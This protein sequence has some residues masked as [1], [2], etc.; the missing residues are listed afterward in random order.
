MSPTISSLFEEQVARTPGAPA[1]Q[2]PDAGRELSYRDLS[3]EANRL[4]QALVARGLP[5]AGTVAVCLPQGVDRI[6]AFLAAGKAGA[7]YVSMDPALPR[8]RHE[9][10]AGDS[11]ADIV[12]TVEE[13]AGHFPG[14]PALLVD[15]DR[16]EIAAMP[17]EAPPARPANEVAIIYYTSGTTGTPKG[18]LASHEGVAHFLRSLR[19]PAL[20]P[21]DRMAQINNPAFDA[22]TFEVYGALTSG[23]C[24]VIISRDLLTDPAEFGEAIKRHGITTA[25]VATSVFHEIAAGNPAAFAPMRVL[26][27]GGEALDPRR[28]RDVLAVGRPGHLLNAYGP[29]ETT[30]FVTWHEVTAVADD[31]RFIPIGLPLGE[32]RAYVLDK[33]LRP[34][35][36]GEAG[37]LCLA[38]P[39]LALGYLGRPELT[40]AAFVPDPAVPGELMYRTGDFARRGAGGVLEFTGRIDRQV[41]LRGY[42]IELGEIEAQVV[43]HPD[44]AGGAV[45]VEGE[46]DGRR[47]AAYVVPAQGGDGDI[48][49]RLRAY[50][51][52]RLP[53]W[54]VPGL[55]VLDR[56]PLTPTGKLDRAA[57][58]ATVE[59]RRAEAGRTHAGLTGAD[60]STAGRAHASLTSAGAG[61][62]ALGSAG[63]AGSDQVG[64]AGLDGVAPLESWLAGV[65][66]ELTGIAPKGPDD[67]F[68]VIG[69]HSV[70]VG[71]LRARVRAVLGTQPPLRDY[72]R[73]S[74]LSEQAAMLRRHDAGRNLDALVTALPDRQAQ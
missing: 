34:V 72:F 56:L 46:G 52:E 1:I 22:T 49:G 24:L 69:G 36:D 74:R 19:D 42:R 64:G 43:A 21:S 20:S 16:A 7:A 23:G 27:V 47:L 62:G 38:G 54:M 59:E 70:L 48:P 45:I 73:N 5:A 13:L 40:E 17:P 11:R 39:C 35:P 3:R 26:V 41:K 33:D 10:I 28:A 25:L 14:T 12:I 37:E 71:R 61:A 31:T 53:L 55:T 67:D 60:A 29:T 58:S 8:A 32:V 2:H 15:A 18:V 57:L 65:W 44:V 50:L 63:E 66:T 51:A 30:T 9:F 68:F 4:A 6:A